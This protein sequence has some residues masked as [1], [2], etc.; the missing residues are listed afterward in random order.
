[1]ARKISLT[2]KIDNLLKETP[3]QSRIKTTCWFAL[4]DMI[5]DCG[6][7]EE[8][9]WDETNPRDIELMKLLD[10]KAKELTQEIMEKIKKWEEDGKPQ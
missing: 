7:R 10:D 6:A 1:M 2:E 8:S 3:L 5:H 4:N 9:Y